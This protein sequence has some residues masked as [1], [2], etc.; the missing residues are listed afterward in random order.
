MSGN[1]ETET[2]PRLV[3]DAPEAQ[4]HAGPELSHSGAKALLK[5]PAKYLYEREH[6]VHKDVYDVGTAAHAL[7]LGTPLEIV[8]VD[9][10]DW[11][12]K[13]AR[14]AKE[15]ARGEGKVPLLRDT[16]TEIQAMRE[17]LLKHRT[18]R[19][20]LEREGHSE[21]SVYWTDQET[22]VPLRARFDRLTTNDGRA[23]GLDYK[24]TA[25]A[26]PLGFAKSVASYGYAQQDPWY[27]DG[28]IALGYED[29]SFLFIAQEKSAP[30][31]PAVYEL[32]P[33]DREIGREKNAMARQIW[34]DC[35]EAGVWPA[36]SEDVQFLDLPRWYGF[37]HEMETA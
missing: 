21:A 26:S 6:P 24:S 20:L 3:L 10:D 9:A 29:P 13:A 34:R 4:Y 30:Y 8:V 1:A 36:Y 37:Q 2:A 31:L 22:G 27:L 33:G 5:S 17:A 25:D 18:A 23:L 11:R 19:S 14:E 12:S 35:T 7:V 15:Q 32:R 16:W 28:L